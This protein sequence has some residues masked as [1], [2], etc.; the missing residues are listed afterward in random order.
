MI[1]ASYLSSLDGVEMV[2]GDVTDVESLKLLFQGCTEVISV[3]GASKPKNILPTLFPFLT[4]EDDDPTHSK[5]INY[6]GVQ[7]IVQAS[8]AT[9]IRRIVRITGNNEKPFSF[10]SILLNMLGKMAKGWNYE[11]EQVLR[12]SS[13]IPYTII[14]PGVMRPSI[15]STSKSR[16][17]GDNGTSNLKVSAVSYAQIAELC[18]ECLDYDNCDKSTLVAMNVGEGEGEDTYAP[19]LEKVQPDN[20]HYPTSLIDKHKQGARLGAAILAT[21]LAV[22]LNGFVSL[23]IKLV[24]LFH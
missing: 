1:V 15:P 5:Q 12:T 10:F 8:A 6:V 19:L 16:A 18:I 22:L 24:S 9:T 4:S 20:R 13:T 21:F 17:L 14:R 11:G 23:L 7:N 2:E 3:H